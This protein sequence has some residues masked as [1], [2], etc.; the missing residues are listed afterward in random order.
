MLRN[1]PIHF[2]DF[3]SADAENN[4]YKPALMQKLQQDTNN[5]AQHFIHKKQSQCN[6]KRISGVSY[7][8]KSE[9]K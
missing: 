7:V 2:I 3:N 4:L 6:I 1:Q 9:S 5:A 8:K